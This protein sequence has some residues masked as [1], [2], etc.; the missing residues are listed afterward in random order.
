[1]PDLAGAYGL[2][3]PPDSGERAATLASLHYVTAIRN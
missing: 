2:S 1:V 3:L